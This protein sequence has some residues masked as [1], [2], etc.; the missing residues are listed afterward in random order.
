MFAYHKAN[1]IEQHYVMFSIVFRMLDEWFAEQLKEIVKQCSPRRQTLLFSAT[2]TDRVKDLAT[3]SLKNPSKIFVDSN[4]QVAF[5]LSQQFVK[6]E[7]FFF[8]LRG[9]FV[10]FI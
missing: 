2:M 4:K 9:I 3:V 7:L 10:T 6:Y 5:K 1:F 8:V